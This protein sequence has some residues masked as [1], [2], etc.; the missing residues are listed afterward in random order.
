M[1][2]I[3]SGLRSLTAEVKRRKIGSIAI[4]AL[5]CGLGGLDWAQVRP[6]IV[7]AF[8]DLPDVQVYLFEPGPG[9]Q[10]FASGPVVCEK[11]ETLSFREER[12]SSPN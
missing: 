11:R 4:P 9:S 12:P 2:D 3:E 6:R 1:E 8:E 7:K 10:P 5:G